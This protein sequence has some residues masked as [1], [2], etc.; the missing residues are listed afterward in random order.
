MHIAYSIISVSFQFF[1][2]L[3]CRLCVTVKLFR[4]KCFWIVDHGARKRSNAILE[5]SFVIWVILCTFLVSTRLIF[6]SVS[7]QQISTQDDFLYKKKQFTTKKRQV[8][9]DTK[10]EIKKERVSEWRK[11]RKKHQK[12]DFQQLN[13]VRVYALIF[14]SAKK[15]YLF[16]H[17]NNQL[18]AVLLHSTC[19]N[20]DVSMTSTTH[21]TNKQEKQHRLNTNMNLIGIGVHSKKCPMPKS[22]LTLNIIS[23]REH[24]GNTCFYFHFM[25]R[26]FIWKIRKVKSSLLL[27]SSFSVAVMWHLIYHLFL[28]CLDKS[29]DNI[30]YL[31]FCFII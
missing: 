22:M 3:Y 20:S 11:R 14:I 30:I 6:G 31:A 26:N 8:W 24:W 15:S 1:V 13:G 2:W 19:W 21:R 27:C 18:G 29:P 17:N 7:V 4:W 10:K 5:F 12:S 9:Q 23:I 25:P 16:R 28:R